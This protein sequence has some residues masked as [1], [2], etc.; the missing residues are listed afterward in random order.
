MLYGKTSSSANASKQIITKEIM[1][2]VSFEEPRSN[3]K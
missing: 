2:K 1:P 3:K